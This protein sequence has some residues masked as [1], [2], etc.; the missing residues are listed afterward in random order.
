MNNINKIIIII[1]IKQPNI[2]RSH[3]VIFIVTKISSQ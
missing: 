2:F 3:T 1:I